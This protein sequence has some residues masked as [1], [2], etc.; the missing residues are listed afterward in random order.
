MMRAISV[1]QK[2]KEAERNVKEYESETCF[3]IDDLDK[4]PIVMGAKKYPK[5]TIAELDQ[6]NGNVTV[7]IGSCKSHIE[8]E[9]RDAKSLGK[10]LVNMLTTFK[11]RVVYFNVE[12]RFATVTENILKHFH[13]KPYI[14]DDIKETIKMLQE[15]IGETNNV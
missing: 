4:E 7:R 14:E 15:L 9:W 6:F 12:D 5:K 10:W 2:L 1:M 13:L 11:Q 3:Q 8:L